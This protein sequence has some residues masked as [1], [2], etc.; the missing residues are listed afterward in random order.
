MG[1][2]LELGVQPP[3]PAQFLSEQPGA[4]NTLFG[5]QRQQFGIFKS[6]DSH[7]GNLCACVT[8]LQASSE[9][10]DNRAKLPSSA[11]RDLRHSLNLH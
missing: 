9:V 5:F 2:A 10:P 11:A 1:M 6:P 3:A 8:N 7:A 4:Q